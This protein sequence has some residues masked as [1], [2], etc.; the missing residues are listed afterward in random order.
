MMLAAMTG[1]FSTTV[2]AR[3]DSSLDQETEQGVRVLLQAV[4]QELRQAGACLT[5]LGEFIALEGSNSGTRDSL[6]LRIG[7]T[8]PATGRCI[9]VGTTAV[10]SPGSDTLTVT[11]ASIFLP[12]ET[13]YITPDSVNGDFYTVE[14]ASGTMLTLTTSLVDIGGG[15]A[16]YPIGTGVYP[17]DEREYAVDSS[18][19]TNPVF[20]VSLNG[21]GPYPLI[22]GVDVFDVKYG[23][24]P[25]DQGVASDQC[26]VVD[27]PA[28]ETE[29]RSIREVK[30]KA[31][32]KSRKVDKSGQ[33]HSAVTG[34]S[35][36]WNEYVTI[37]P[38]NFL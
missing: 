2:S 22:S 5:Q 23:I 11:D 37:K 26:T 15:G 3:Y 33:Y 20:T 29:W 14:Q 38:R 4:T 34:Q 35:G 21:S 25:C 16:P 6:L 12:G 32:V 13:V 10:S 1:F 31:S 7:R 24:L 30:I 17:L 27:F 28:D 36:A 19:S 18:D 9:Q 8:N